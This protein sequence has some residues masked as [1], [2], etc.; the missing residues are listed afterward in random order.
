MEQ[1]GIP[2]IERTEFA[3]RWEYLSSQEREEIASM[4][5]RITQLLDHKREQ[6]S[7]GEKD[8]QQLV[9]VGMQIAGCAPTQVPTP[10]VSI[11]PKAEAR[12]AGSELRD[13]VQSVAQTA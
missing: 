9:F 7:V 1:D 10:R 3:L 2:T 5:T 8:D 4:M 12:S 13:N 11:V 6:K